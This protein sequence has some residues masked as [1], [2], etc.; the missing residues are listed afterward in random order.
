MPL[1]VLLQDPSVWKPVFKSSVPSYCPR[2]F[3]KA[4]KRMAFALNK[5][6][7]KIFSASKLTPKF[8][9][10][11]AVGEAAKV[12]KETTDTCGLLLWLVPSWNLMNSAGVVDRLSA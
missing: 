10:I 4:E 9:V 2:H 6:G 8:H 7:H 1:Q 12:N 5:A 11:V 3:R